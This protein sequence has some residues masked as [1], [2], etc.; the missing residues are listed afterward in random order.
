MYLDS[1]TTTVN[2]KTYTR[3]LLRESYRDQGQVKKRTVANLRGMSDEEAGAIRLALRHK[4][5]LAHL[6]SVQE[7]VSLQQGLSVGA[8]WL[9]YKLAEELGILRALGPSRQGKLALW[10][11]LARVMEQG[12]RLSAVRLAGRHAACDVLGIQE[13][14]HED[15]LYANLDWLAANQDP[16]EQKLFAQLYPTGKPEL[17]LYDV[18]STYLEGV[19][20]ELAAFG[21]NRDGKRGKKQLVVGLLCD[22][23]GRALSV[24]AFQGNTQDP[25][26]FA[27]QVRK[28][29]ERFGGSD[30]TFVGDRGM[31]K[32]AQ[33]QD[34]L[35]HGF[36][37]I[38]AITK[39]QIDALVR[40]GVIQMELF[41]EDLA[42]VCSPEGLRYVLR[43]NPLRA[44]QVRANRE[45][46]L[47]SLQGQLDQHNAYL[48]DHPRARVD[49]ALRRVRA[50]AERL[51]IGN[52]V[53]V[54]E[55]GR[56]LSLRVDEAAL[57]EVGRLD[58]CYVLKTDL[59]EA[60]A[61]AQVVHERYQDLTLVEQGFRTCKT[62]HLEMRPVHVRLARRTRGHLFVVMLAYRI[63]KE[64]RVRWQDLDVTVE[65]GVG[66]VATVCAMEVLIDGTP[67]CNKIPKPNESVAGLLDAAQVRLPEALPHRRVRVV[68]RKKLQDRRTS[69]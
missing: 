25:Q 41:D 5:N 63:V 34:L 12:S 43:R 6:G 27:P 22:P 49:T 13:P 45:D 32:S 1:S 24:E 61:S 46:K 7:S 4:D 67:R 66:E 39:P 31:I 30:V 35:G 62:V 29:A 55:S 68:T 10:Q 18:T 2:G 11:V 37:Y 14:F 44:E 36:H 28:V 8:V 54:C 64:L 65:E 52:W 20:N 26:T 53:C 19:E 56:R 69:N 58:G 48:R 47:A 40:Q 51:R 3:H 16:I 17:F 38:T 33:V 57:A 59:C 9:L 42:E 21:Y 50:R 60:R 15:H 23:A